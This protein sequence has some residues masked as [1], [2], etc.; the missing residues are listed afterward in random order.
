[1]QEVP[2]YAF[3][4]D[5]GAMSEQVR[6]F[7]WAATA[8]GPM[9][10]WSQALRVA[11]QMVLANA[12]PSCLVWGPGMVTLY[13]D[14]F[15]PI[16]GSK[17]NALGRSFGDIWSDAWPTI[18]PIAARAL[19][20]E[21]TFI[22]DFPLTLQRNGYPEQA[23]F[24]FSYS[25]V[26]NEHG[27]VVGFLDTVVE[28]TRSVLTQ[29]QTDELAASFERQVAERTADRNR[30]WELSSD[31]ILVAEPDLKIV[32]INP[33]WEHVLGWQP[34]CL[35]GN[36][37]LGLVHVDDRATVL[38]AAARLADGEA[39]QDMNCRLRDSR[40]EYRWINWAAVP[41]DGFFNAVGRD[42]TQERERAEALRQAEDLLRHSQ[43][44][45][46]VGQLTGGLAH[47]FN[48]LLTGITGSLELLRRRVAQQRFNE[49]DRY[50][51]AA[52]GA[53]NRAATLTHRL[54]AFARRQTLDPRPTDVV[55][56]VDDLR[57]L[58]RQTL[59]P[60][61]AL[62]WQPQAAVWTVLV[63]ANQLESTLLNLCINARDAMPDGGHLALQVHHHQQPAPALADDDLPPGQY[64]CLSVVDTGTG[65]SPE[66]IARA[67]DPFFTTKPIGQGTGLGLSM[68]YG[69]ARQSGGRVRI[70][71]SPGQGTAVRLYLPRH[72]GPVQAPDAAPAD[73]VARPARL[74]ESV[75]LIDDE[76]T[77][78]TLVAEQL[79][80]M[81]YQVHQAGDGVAGLALL[82]MTG[83]VD[84]LI[85]DVGLPGGLNG[86]QVADAAA[87]IRPGLKVLF[88]TGYAEQVLVKRSQLEPGMRLLVK[89]FTLQTLTEKVR[90]LLD[91]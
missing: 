62:D 83:E 65:M 77:L 21:S 4:P 90:S 35:R 88:I 75:V 45:E 30:L 48:N 78:R 34:G 80:E 12:F 73:L 2:E 67:F 51:D 54:L 53:A 71:S 57:D 43:K 85:T 86:R 19:A 59:G 24:T 91:E 27:Q 76:V 13:N 23:W 14:A 16:L 72:L 3:L 8:L 38:A 60:T 69:F 82:Q 55:Q 33:A 26:R 66:V 74:G 56:L 41:G 42:V 50:L 20:G 5:R 28:T 36:S 31:I 68:V 87:R 63:D 1:M 37:V 7:D 40:G 47:D 61:V 17:S 79:E 15:V 10:H 81:G 46:A 52:H 22:E 84:L 64:L 49:L 6:R 25:P 39:V 58:I 70:E 44:M 32:A 18:G 11:V 9:E 89:P 29:R